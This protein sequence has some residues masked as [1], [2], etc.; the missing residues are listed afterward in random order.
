MNI[1]MFGKR[2]E[3]CQ[4]FGCLSRFPT[5]EVRND[6]VLA[7]ADTSLVFASFSNLSQMS[8]KIFSLHFIGL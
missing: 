4:I 1:L 2:L 8:V 5:E 3:Q 7:V 6:N